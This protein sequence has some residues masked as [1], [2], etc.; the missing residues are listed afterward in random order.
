M[1]KI[2]LF[3]ALF[4][5]MAVSAQY[6]SESRIGFTGNF[7]QGS[8]VNIHDASKGRYGGTLGVVAEI[9]IV[10]A[11]ITGGENIFLMPMV[12]YSM[13]GENSAV[14]S[15]KYGRQKFHNDYVAAQLYL[16]YFFAPGRNLSE[17]FVF[18]GPRV[19]FLVRDKRVTSAQYEASYF[20]YNH[21]DEMNKIGIAVSVGVG[22]R[23]MDNLEAFLR[24]DRGFSKVY[25]NAI[26]GVTYNRQLSVGVNYY[27]G[28][29]RYY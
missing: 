13:Q 18:A 8:I 17:Y 10:S 1:K 12:E 28:G 26:N 21:D 3:I 25:P 7:H 4:L 27:L 5:F 6:S 16:K 24:F 22:T 11:D 19:E 23:I 14:E 29:N 20:Q 2:N 9:P 15:G